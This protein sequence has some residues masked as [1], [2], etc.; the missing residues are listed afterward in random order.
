LEYLKSEQ[1]KTNYVYYGLRADEQ[2]KGFV[3]FGGTKIIPKY[4]LQEVGLDLNGVWALLKGHDLLPPTF[5]GERLVERVTK[6]A[7]GG[8]TLLSE[9][10]ELYLFSGRSRANCSFCFFQ[11]QYEFLWLLETHPDL[12]E[13]ASGLEKEDYTWRQGY[14]L[15]DLKENKRWQQ[16]IFD[17]RVNTI[18][19][20][21]NA[22]RQLSIPGLETENEL[23][24]YS[25]GLICGK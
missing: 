9:I 22:K 11:R 12:F 7:Q 19:T 25:C 3:P 16:D 10:E 17:R 14:S 1:G 24:F 6:K 15:K 2:R 4:P 21:I 5:R 23:S 13:R 20:Y 18:L 8:E